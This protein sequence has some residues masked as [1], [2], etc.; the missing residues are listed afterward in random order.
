VKPL[1]IDIQNVSKA[2]PFESNHKVEALEQISF[3]V[4]EKEF[5][6]LLGPSG[7]GKSTLL[8]LISG[9]DKADQGRIL[10]EEAVVN[11]PSTD[12]GFIFQDY[13]LFPWLNVRNNIRFGLEMQG[14][15][16][17]TQNRIV[18]EY[19]RLFGLEGSAFLYPKQLS[20]GMRQRVAIARA[21]CLKPKLLLM[22]EPFAALDAMLRQKLQEE[23]V[24][25]WDIEKITCVLVTH[26]IEEA[27]YLADRIII[28]TPSPGRIK[29][30]VQV[31]LPRPRIRTS[32]EFV[33]VRSKLLNLLNEDQPYQQEA[34]VG[35]S[36]IS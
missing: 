7:C 3:S 33:Q 30:I 11:N 2:Y 16:S 26:D 12:R 32:L 28:M 31:Q 36:A 29:E 4:K 10:F 24:R 9:M 20:G 15:P 34:G 25:I 1:L 22:D 17:K 5:I 6:C 27:V 35:V 19:V 14:L 13:A 21:L 23:L 8:K 18:Q